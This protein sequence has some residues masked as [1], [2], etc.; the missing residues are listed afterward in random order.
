MICLTFDTDW[1]S[2]EDMAEF[3]EAY[4]DL[5]RSTFFIHEA[6]ADWRPNRHEWGPHP[7]IDPRGPSTSPAWQDPTAQAL[8]IRSHSCVSSHLFS[9]AWA[10]EGFL[11]QSNETRL[12]GSGSAPIRTAW[13]IWEL[14]I[15]YM[16]NMDMWYRRN[17]PGVSHVPFADDVIAAALACESV[18]VFDFHPVH[19]AFNSSSPEDYARNRTSHARGASAWTLG[20]G[21][22]GTRTFFDRLLESIRDAGTATECASEVVLRAQRHSIG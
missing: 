10:S 6:S 1:M 2:A 13:G 5:P 7:T 18:Y 4:P 8:G 19:I 22:G 11:Y 15:S 16:D 14:P 3:L 21:G 12:F 20:A 9:I 17:W